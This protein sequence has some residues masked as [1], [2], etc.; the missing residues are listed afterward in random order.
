M[1]NN[2]HTVSPGLSVPRGRL[3]QTAARTVLGQSCAVESPCDKRPLYP[4][5]YSIAQFAAA[6]GL[7]RSHVYNLFRRG[8]GPKTFTAGRRRLI[9][10]DAVLA[11]VRRNEILATEQSTGG[12][13]P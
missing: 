2:S 4:A 6:F 9:A 5:A 12:A 11:W 13:K 7:S 3:E 10:G 1:L 8:E